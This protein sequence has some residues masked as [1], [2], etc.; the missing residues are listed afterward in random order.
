M[1][2]PHRRYLLYLL[3]RKLGFY[4]ISA[5]CSQHNLVVPSEESLKELAEE[6]GTVPSGWN[7]DMSRATISFRRW[8]RDNQILELWRNTIEVQNATSLLFIEG[9]RKDFEALVLV[10]DSDIIKA[11][12][13]LNRKYGR[14]TPPVAVLETFCRCYWN[15]SD[16]HSQEIYDFLSVQQSREE[17]LPA[18]TGDVARTYALLGLRQEVTPEEFY[19]NMIALSNMQLEMVLRTGMPIGGSKALG[20]SAIFKAGHDAMM[21]RSALRTM[22]GGEDLRHLAQD[23][24]LKQITEVQEIPGIEELSGAEIIDADYEEMDNVAEFP[25]KR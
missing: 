2:Y 17:L 19:D 24:K 23:F 16:M 9:I 5:C 6:L 25:T 20:V 13:G 11:W 22:S 14:R 12:E 3:S 7:L 4:D 18:A 10:H 8:L 21:A 15:I 1:R